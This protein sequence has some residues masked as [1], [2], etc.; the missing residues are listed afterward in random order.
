M[1]AICQLKNSKTLLIPACLFD[2]E[3]IMYLMLNLINLQTLI[4]GEC[5]E[6]LD[7]FFIKLADKLKNVT[8]LKIH[9]SNFTDIGVL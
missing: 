2:S 7:G 1:E 5:S 4:L 8:M 9:D 6:N 3:H